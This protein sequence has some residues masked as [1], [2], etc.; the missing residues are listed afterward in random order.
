MIARR[1]PA[2]WCGA[3]GANGPV[4]IDRL[5]VLSEGTTQEDDVEGLLARM[6]AFAEAGFAA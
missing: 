5:S 3:D 2:L 1:L 6:L 4:R